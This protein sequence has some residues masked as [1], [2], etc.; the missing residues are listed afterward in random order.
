M[1]MK[2][3]LRIRE[4]GLER[5]QQARQSFLIRCEIQFFLR[6]ESKGIYKTEEGKGKVQGRGWGGGMGRH[7]WKKKEIPV[8]K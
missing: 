7:G 4:T 5:E 8:L 2:S 6:Q 3:C 1:R